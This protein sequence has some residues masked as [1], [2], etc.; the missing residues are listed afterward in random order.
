[1][2]NAQ[3][4]LRKLAAQAHGEVL[5]QLMEAWR[6]RDAAAVPTAQALGKRGGAQRTQW[7]Q[8]LQGGAAGD[9]AQAMLRLEVA[10]D[11]PTPAAHLAE[12]RALQLQL[13]TQRHDPA[14]DQTWGA[15]VARVLAAGHDEAQA[16]RL[17]ATLKVLLKP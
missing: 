4:A 13:L 7:A 1:M 14:P 16:R 10:A 2:E 6:T 3:A 11:L 9:A 17:Q 15:D 8:A 5:T 12:R